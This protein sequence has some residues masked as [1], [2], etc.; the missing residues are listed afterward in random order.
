M[1]VSLHVIQGVREIFHK[2]LMEMES[3]SSTM[4]DGGKTCVIS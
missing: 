2:V 1:D 4:S 3:D